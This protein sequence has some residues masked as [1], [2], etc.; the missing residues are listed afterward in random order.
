MKPA[1]LEFVKQRFVEYYQKQNLIAPSSLEQRE[2]G[3][4]FDTTSDVRMRRRIA[5]MDPQARGL[6]EEPGARPRLLLTAY[7]R[8]TVGAD[9][10]RSTGPAPT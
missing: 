5:F 8:S 6:R 7:Y 1:T 9:D 3:F 4:V 10:E 2:W